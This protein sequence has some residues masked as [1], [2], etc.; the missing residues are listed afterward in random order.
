MPFATGALGYKKTGP[1]T[2][3]RFNFLYEAIKHVE[4]DHRVV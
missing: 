4:R 3:S 1:I 2:G